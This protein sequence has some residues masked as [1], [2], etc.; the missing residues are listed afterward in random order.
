M[1]V[2]QEYLDAILHRGRVAMEPLDFQPNWQDRPRKE[3][4]YPG[5]ESY[6]MPPGDGR[7]GGT[8][9]EG[10]SLP[11]RGAPSEVPPAG[12]SFTLARLG[13]LLLDSYGQLTRRL[14][15]HANADV[16]ALPHYASAN[17]SRGTS[18]GGGLYP[19]SI[20]WVAGPSGP[21]TPGVYYYSP[22]HHAVQRLLAGDVTG[23]VR[24]AVGDPAL[25]GDTDQFL[26]L[27]IKFWQNS[28]KYNSFSYHAVT[29][30]IGTLV[31]TWRMS[32]NAEGL[33]IK[34]V[35]WFDEPR[36]GRLLGV[37]SREEGVFAVVPLA[38]DDAQPERLAPDGAPD[39]ENSP[40]VRYIDVERSRAVVTFSTLL[41]VHAATLAG[42]TTR[43]PPLVGTGV[44]VT[45]RVPG[46][47]VPLPPPRRMDV[48]VREA[49]RSR[50]SSFGRF[51]SQPAMDPEQLSA[52]LAAA[53][54][55]AAFPSDVHDEHA[56]PLAKIYV[57]VNHVAGVEPG[58]YEH[59]PVANELHLVTS[60]PPGAFLQ[61]S[62]F[63]ANYNI[64]QASAVIVATAPSAAVMLAAGDR[65]YRLANATIGAVCQAVYAACAA[66]DLGCGAALGIDNI[67]YVEELGLAGTGEAPLLIIMVGVEGRSPADFRYE[68]A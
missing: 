43:P 40:Q 3:K 50:R 7:P 49:L 41:A 44:T 67:S 60:G 54:S 22:Q 30:D 21:L 24:A 2:T 51:S 64:E 59:D 6:P 9:D 57:F 48:G 47:V 4:S 55:G 61:P 52:L 13:G 37:E 28:F 14:A 39:P 26:V 5:V 56:A 38:W 46:Q 8:L 58:A 35:L 19:V 34:P 20:Y 29:M 18:S 68:I 53:S 33:D 16:A 23:E 12:A 42:A 1:T 27:G 62:Y 17:W 36:L 63:L 25:L 15:V 45:A 31:Q 32:A 10:L 66:L 11:A 65:G